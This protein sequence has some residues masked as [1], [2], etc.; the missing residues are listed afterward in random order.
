LETGSTVS[1][2]LNFCVL[3]AERRIITF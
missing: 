3:L 1:Q 2:V